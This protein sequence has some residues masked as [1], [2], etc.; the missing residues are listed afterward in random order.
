[1]DILE[2]RR[3][4]FS[5]VAYFLGEHTSKR[6]YKQNGPTFAETHKLSVLQSRKIQEL[7]GRVSVNGGEG[8]LE[9]CF[10]FGSI[11]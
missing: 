9:G 4:D 10:Y 3:R 1:M 8:S 7:I 2:P 6:T 5:T 11:C